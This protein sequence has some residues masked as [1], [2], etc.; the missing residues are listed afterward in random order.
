MDDLLQQGI[1][2]FQAGKRDDSRKLFASAIQKNPNDESAWGWMYNVCDN[3]KERIDCLKQVLRINPSNEKA[4]RLF[5]KL[6]GRSL[7]NIPFPPKIIPQ[8]SNQILSQPKPVVSQTPIPQKKNSHTTLYVILISA[9]V[10]IFC[11]GIAYLVDKSGGSNNNAASPYNAKYECEVFVKDR[12]KAPST[13]K[14]SNEQAYTLQTQT[15]AFQV[16]GDVDAQNGFGAMLR[17][18]FTCDVRR[19]SVDSSGGE[20]WNLI[21]LDMSP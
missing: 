13:A 14:F 20:E 8:K 9:L 18:S 16:T 7:T 19:V 1:T 6:S 3:D 11:G 10:I 4:N 17:N 21:N 12:L 5:N 2:A 15:D